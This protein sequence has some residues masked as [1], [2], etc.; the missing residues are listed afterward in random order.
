MSE[1]FEVGVTLALSDGVSES[2]AST[3]KDMARLEQV[4]QTGGVSVQQ[5][6]AAASEI[7]SVRR[8]PFPLRQPGGEN[9]K[10]KPADSEAVDFERAQGLPTQK[11]TET[12]SPD[13]METR[14]VFVRQLTDDALP[15]TTQPQPSQQRPA[16]PDVD[17]GPIGSSV[18]ASSDR[19]DAFAKRPPQATESQPSPVT[20]AVP[21]Y[22]VPQSPAW[23]MQAVSRTDDKA[24]QQSAGARVEA[25]QPV[26]HSDSWWTQR[27]DS[28]SLPV[29]DSAS[30]ERPSTPAVD[31]GVPP[32]QPSTPAVD[33]GVPP[34]QQSSLVN[35]RE[36]ARPAAPVSQANPAS[37]FEPGDD[38]DANPRQAPVA[39]MMSP[40]SPSPTEGDIFLDGALMGRWMSKHL[41]AQ[42][43]RASA[44]P[45]GFDPRRG[46]LLP[47]A[48]VGN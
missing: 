29:D 1:A 47:G 36:Q 6:R 4:L 2:I 38:D 31:A 40:S 5:L 16:A 15:P 48:T 13:R 42:V 21:A 14:E 23:S 7:M 22:P 44:G 19:H 26:D 45:T 8:L 32:R 41:T 39:P 10:T 12:N 43:G 25:P 9:S 3:R 30:A 20:V 27:R 28:F 24:R 17:A 34:W 35:S 18:T 11:V 37:G 46:R 33:A